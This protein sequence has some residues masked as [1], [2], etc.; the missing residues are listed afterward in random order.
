MNKIFSES[1]NQPNRSSGGVKKRAS[2]RL[3][4]NDEMQKWLD[5]NDQLFHNNYICFDNNCCPGC[6]VVLDCEI[7]SSKRCPECKCKIVLRTNK[8]SSK[9]LLLTEAEATKFDKDDESIVTTESFN[10]RNYNKKKKEINNLKDEIARM[11]S[12]MAGLMANPNKS[13]SFSGQNQ[14]NPQDSLRNTPRK[15]D[16]LEKE[17]TI[18]TIENLLEKEK[19]KTANMENDLKKLQAYCGELENKIQILESNPQAKLPID[20]ESDKLM[21]GKDNKFTPDLFI[22]MFFDI[23]TKLFSSSE[24]KKFYSIYVSDNIIG[25]IEIFTKNCDMIK[26]QIYEAKFDVDTSYTDIEETLLNSRGKDKTT[27]SYRL[28]NDRIIKLKKFEFDFINLSEFL[29]NYLVAQELVVKMSFSDSNE[30]QFEPI[31]HLYKLFEDCLNYQID[32]MNDDI[33]FQRKLILRYAKN[34]KNCLGLSL[35]CT[36][37]T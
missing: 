12:E 35:E 7:K 13:V 28:V 15:R 17:N 16:I 5:N 34:Q 20:E 37:A 31:E 27:N 8:E 11:K 22:Q 29:K 23:N 36:F 19:E 2:G 21:A 10:E 3:I 33:I 26:R 25:V 4:F 14:E 24:L 18:K 32:D 9:K 30:I 1:S 6:G